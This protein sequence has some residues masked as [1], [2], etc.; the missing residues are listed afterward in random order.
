MQWTKPVA[1]DM[2]HL[3]YTKAEQK[4]LHLL[5]STNPER[6]LMQLRVMIE[7]KSKN[8]TSDVISWGEIRRFWY[9]IRNSQFANRN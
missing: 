3:E 4:E 8:C 6:F 5:C 7:K 1:L 9:V 2:R